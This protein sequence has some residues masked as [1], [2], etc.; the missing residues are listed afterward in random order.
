[1]AHHR[2]MAGRALD[3]RGKKPQAAVGWSR[4]IW[5]SLSWEYPPA[6]CPSSWIPSADRVWTSIRLRPSKCDPAGCRPEPTHRVE[7]PA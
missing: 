4:K 3:W 7:T 1:M 2:R 6:N 5:R